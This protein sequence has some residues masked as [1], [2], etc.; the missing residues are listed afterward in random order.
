MTNSGAQRKIR[1][2]PLFACK[3]LRGGGKKLEK[4]EPTHPIKKKSLFF[5]RLV[6]ILSKSYVLS[7]T[8]LCIFSLMQSNE[9][10]VQLSHAAAKG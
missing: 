9:K 1:S 8:I 7:E 6:V 2:Q 4:S 3:N 5:I 10:E